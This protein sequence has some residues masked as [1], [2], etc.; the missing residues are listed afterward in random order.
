MSELE[1]YRVID[2]LKGIQMT[3]TYIDPDQLLTEKEAASILCYT[4]RA[5]QNWRVRGGGPKF[6]K[7]SARSIRY[8][9]SALREWMD[10]RTHAHTSSFQ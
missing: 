10:E 6:V 4:P 3:E 1:Q 9:R 2:D 8:R 7:V 5:L